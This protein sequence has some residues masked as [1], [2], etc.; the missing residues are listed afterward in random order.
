MKLFR[1]VLR[2]TAAALLLIS[3]AVGSTAFADAAYPTRPIKLVVPYAP[4]G[5]NDV[6]LR[7]VSKPELGT[8]KK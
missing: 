6:T 5:A 8:F 3:Y 4:G 1:H 2:S 7:L